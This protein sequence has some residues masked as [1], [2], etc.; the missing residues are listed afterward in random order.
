MK[1]LFPLA[2]AE[3]LVNR[4]AHL[5]RGLSGAKLCPVV[6]GKE[7]G[8]EHSNSRPGFL[9]FLLPYVLVRAPGEGDS[10]G[11]EHAQGQVFQTVF[12]PFSFP[13]FKHSPRVFGRVGGG[14][15]LGLLFV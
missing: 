4:L 5:T 1:H 2:R 9:T 3:L 11:G 12:P 15:Y 13:W 10:R 7:G 14:V 6:I 8:T